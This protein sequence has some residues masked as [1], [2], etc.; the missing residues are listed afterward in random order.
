SARIEEL[1]RALA[2]SQRGRDSEIYEVAAEDRSGNDNTRQ[3][4][5]VTNSSTQCIPEIVNVTDIDSHIASLIAIFLNAHP[6]GAN[7]DYICSYVVKTHSALTARDTESL[8]R[9]FPRLFREESTGIGA[10]LEK[11]WAFVGFKN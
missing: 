4:V 11:K 5:S 8:M 6:F 9:K 10:T 3:N 7:I 2:E 1:E